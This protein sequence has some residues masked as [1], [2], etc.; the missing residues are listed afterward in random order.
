MNLQNLLPV[1]KPL[2]YRYRNTSNCYVTPHIYMGVTDNTS[3]H[4]DNAP[5]LHFEGLHPLETTAFPGAFSLHMIVNHGK[6]R[7]K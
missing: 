3:L 5:H 6:E 4:N 7:L 1:M 2:P